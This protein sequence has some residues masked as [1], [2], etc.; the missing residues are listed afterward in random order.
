MYKAQQKL[1][2][3]LQKLNNPKLQREIENLV[4]DLVDEVVEQIEARYEISD[5]QREYERELELD[6]MR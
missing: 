3:T 5:A 6:A 2:E 1:I 4:C